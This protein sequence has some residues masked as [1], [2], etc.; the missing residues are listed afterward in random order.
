MTAL[1]LFSTKKKTGHSGKGK[2]SKKETFFV[3]GK[4]SEDGQIRKHPV[5]FIFGDFLRKITNHLFF[6]LRLIP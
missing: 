1:F 4:E 2:V 5:S 6:T 3:F